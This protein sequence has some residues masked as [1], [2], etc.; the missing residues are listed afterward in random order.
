M[1]AIILFYLNSKCT[2][3]HTLCE[4]LLRA[5]AYTAAA[6]RHYR[7][8]CNQIPRRL[9]RIIKELS[10]PFE[11]ERVFVQ[12]LLNWII[13]CIGSVSWTLC[14]WCNLPL[15]FQLVYKLLRPVLA[16]EFIVY[17]NAFFCIIFYIY[18]VWQCLTV[19]C[20]YFFSYNAFDV[21]SF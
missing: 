1:A 17:L 21:K 11:M 13:S 2:G 20:I 10:S 9:C 15:Q 12:H 8:P 4:I 6:R 3:R 14:E 19:L 16:M 7:Q 18:T 5:L